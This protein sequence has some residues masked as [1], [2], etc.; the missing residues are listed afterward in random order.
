MSP[1]RPS[2]ARNRSTLIGRLEFPSA[3]SAQSV[4]GSIQCEFKE[5]TSQVDKIFFNSAGG[6]LCTNSSD[7]LQVT[8][9]DGVFLAAEAGNKDWSAA[10]EGFIWSPVAV[11]TDRLFSFV[12]IKTLQQKACGGDM[13]AALREIIVEG[14]PMA[15]CRGTLTGEPEDKNDKDTSSVKYQCSQ[16]EVTACNS[17]YTRTTNSKYIQCG[18]SDSNCLS[19]GPL[20]LPD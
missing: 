14:N 10:S 1:V 4:G 9:V 8:K 15:A 16:Q 17:K 2:T 5:G 11:D 7:R 3:K 6:A 18:M 19:I 12:I 13:V 20:C